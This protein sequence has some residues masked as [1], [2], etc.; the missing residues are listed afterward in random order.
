MRKSYYA[1]A[2]LVRLVSALKVVL[3]EDSLKVA[4]NA[5]VFVSS[6]MVYTN[7]FVVF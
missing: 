3:L 5:S 4:L 7:H 1:C 2:L 6:F